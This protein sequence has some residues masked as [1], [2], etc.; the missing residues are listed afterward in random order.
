HYRASGRT[1][2]LPEPPAD[3][4][5]AAVVALDPDLYWRLDETSGTV[6]ADAGLSGT[7]GTFRGGVS[8]GTDGFREGS[9]AATFDGAGAMVASDRTFTN[10]RT[11]STELWFRTTTTA[12]GKLIGFGNNP[13][14]T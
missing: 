9:R 7:H 13:T 4:Y 6:A 2:D 5:G 14:G 1:L 3:A 10:P 8:L 12:G 11:Y